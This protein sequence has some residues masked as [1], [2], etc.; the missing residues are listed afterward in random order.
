MIP[1]IDLS[2]VI[3]VHTTF[4]DMRKSI[5]GLAILVRLSGC[6][7]EHGKAFVFLNKARVS[8]GTL[9]RPAIG[10]LMRPL[11]TLKFPP[12][13]PYFFSILSSFY[14]SFF[15]IICCDR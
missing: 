3:F 1:M 5:N 14:S 2:N 15:C 10:T 13:I 7:F 6:V 11:Q 9:I 12:I 4:V 8:I